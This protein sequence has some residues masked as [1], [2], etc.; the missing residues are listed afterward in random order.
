M[1]M[2][3]LLLLLLRFLHT[4]TPTAVP[5]VSYAKHI[6]PYSYVQHCDKVHTYMTCS[7]TAKPLM[8]C[9]EGVVLDHPAPLAE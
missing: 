6:C 5:V 8:A 9:A 4:P 3:M 2:L 7:P 1:M